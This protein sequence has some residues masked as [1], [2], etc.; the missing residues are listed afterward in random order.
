MF[1]RALGIALLTASPAAASEADRA[2][3]AGPPGPAL[4]DWSGP[5][6]GIFAGAGVSTGEARRGD[7][8]GPLI[9]LDVQNGLFH[10]KVD[11]T[12][13]DLIGGVSAGYNLQRG[14][15]V[16]G[17]EGDLML[18]DFDLH[19]RISEIDPNPTPPFTGLVTRTNFETEFGP[20]ATARLRAGIAFDNTL[21]YATGGL[22]VGQVENSFI[23]R[24]PQLAY[25]SPGWSEDGINFGYAIG[26]GAEHRI[27]SNIALKLEAMFID[28]EDNTIHAVDNVTF[29][30]ETIDYRFKNELF[31][32]RIGLS[33]AF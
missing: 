24:L 2:A 5:Y 31:I 22:A 33:F 1:R 11:H 16:F 14:Q 20:I 6:V 9:T 4:A 27:T 17:V 3:F 12:E 29:P 13:V 21:L 15:F 7:I 26:L 8:G 18:A 32:G 19:H 10:D 28:L 25:S 30:G 23:L